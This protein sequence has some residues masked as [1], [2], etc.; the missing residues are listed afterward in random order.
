MRF[1]E[2]QASVAKN[3]TTNVDIAQDLDLNDD[4]S[5]VGGVLQA[6]DT[7]GSI[8][9]QDTSNVADMMP[10]CSSS[11][12]ASGD[13][14]TISATVKS[15]FFIDNDNV[16]QYWNPTKRTFLRDRTGRDWPMLYGS[17]CAVLIGYDH[18]KSFE[19]RK[20]NAAFARLNGIYNICD[21]THR[22]EIMSS[23]FNESI[24]STG[25]HEYV[26]VN[27]LSVLVLVSGKF[28]K[29]ITSQT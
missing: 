2:D 29:K 21:A 16:L 25:K 15:E 24:D 6:L 22:Y 10:K 3:I 8:A 20:R 28:H 19:L 14:D 17:S 5:A 13:D 12:S 7:V 4:K 26:V 11:S 27:G 23:P 18:V 1:S 9:D